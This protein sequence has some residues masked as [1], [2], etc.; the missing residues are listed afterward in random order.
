V[1]TSQYKSG[2]T[3]QY[4]R[5]KLRQCILARNPKYNYNPRP[6]TRASSLQSQYY[7]TIFFTREVTSQ[8]TSQNHG[9]V[10]TPKITST[11]PSQQSRYIIHDQRRV[12]VFKNAIQTQYNQARRVTSIYS[13]LKSR[14]S[15]QARITEQ[16]SRLKLRQ[17]IQASN[18]G[19]LFTTKEAS[20]HSSTQSCFEF[21]IPISRHYIFTRE[22]T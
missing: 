20:P 17:R 9:T 2:V 10:F 14:N 15:L 21:A 12:T 6:R 1:D 11:Y 13:R 16:Y 3:A 22:V 4:S 5:L 18:H 8:F 19:I 7:V